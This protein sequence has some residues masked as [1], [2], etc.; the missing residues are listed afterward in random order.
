M[1]V[2]EAASLTRLF[3]LESPDGG[4]LCE[5]AFSADGA[6]LAAGT[7]HRSVFVWDLRAAR[8][9]LRTLGLDWSDAALPPV[10]GPRAPL[11]LVIDR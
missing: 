10:P 6:K 8:E 5:V 7:V 9:E 1:Q 3:E 4:D 11:R 2:C